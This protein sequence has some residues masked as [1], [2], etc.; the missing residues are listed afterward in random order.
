MVFLADDADQVLDPRTSWRGEPTRLDEH[1]FDALD[2]V[3]APVFAAVRH[4]CQTASG[5]SYF[6]F[7][8]G[9]YRPTP[10]G[11]LRLVVTSSSGPGAGLRDSEASWVARTVTEAIASWPERPS[12]EIIVDHA[13]LHE[14]D[15]KPWA[16][17]AA[18]Q[19]VAALLSPGASQWDDA[20]I[21][22]ITTSAFRPRT[23]LSSL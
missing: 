16:W 15:N 13:L 18:A 5:G 12:G 11:A 8:G 14:V 10:S 23:S 22:E 9:S 17:R 3:D 1:T 6:V 2:R 4:A 21:D 7:L 19:V 20:K